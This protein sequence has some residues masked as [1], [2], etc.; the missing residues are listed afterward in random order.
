MF[1]RMLR[2]FPFAAVAGSASYGRWARLRGFVSRHALGAGAGVI[3]IHLRAGQELRLHDVACWK[4]VC[5][6]GT[7][8]IT[9]EAD[10]RD[11]FLF[12]GDGFEPDRAG[13]ALVR[14]CRDATLS[15][16]PSPGAGA[17]RDARNA[18]SRRGANGSPGPDAARLDWL[19]ALYPETGP[20]NDPASY[21]RSGLL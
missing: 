4:V 14:A 17:P 16:H 8:W 2:P 19:R 15:I 9:Q 3:G 18:M 1:A 21:R 7:V 12:A 20:W 13:L 11:I 10:A 6:S 5:R